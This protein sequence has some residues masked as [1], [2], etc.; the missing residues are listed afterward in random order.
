MIIMSDEFKARLKDYVSS[1][2]KVLLT[3]RTA[4]KDIDNNLVFNKRLPVDID[5]LTGAV[6]EEH[7]TLLTNISSPC[8]YEGIESKGYVFAEMLK[9][10]TAKVLVKWINNPFG[11]YAAATVN[12]YGNG[13]CYYLGSSFDD[14]ILNK[15]FDLILSNN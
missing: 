4:W 7:E 6:I 1:G 3:P 14:A 10:S 5:D 2:G 8:E 13:K 15:L 12:N 9:T 11:D